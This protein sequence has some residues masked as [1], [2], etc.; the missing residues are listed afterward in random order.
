MKRRL[1]LR[2]RKYTIPNIWRHANDEN[3]VTVAETAYI[4]EAKTRFSLMVSEALKGKKVQQAS[5]LVEG[6]KDL[7]P[8]I[9]IRSKNGNPDADRKMFQRISKK[10]NF[11]VH[12]NGNRIYMLKED[13]D[14]INNR[15]LLGMSKIAEYFGIHRKTLT[16]WLKLFRKMPVNRKRDM[17]FKPDIDLWYAILQFNKAKNKEY[18]KLHHKNAPIVESVNRIFI[19]LVQMDLKHPK[20]LKR[21]LLRPEENILR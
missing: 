9:G 15:Y 1:K 8:A 3:S 16:K 2:M 10:Y 13:I 17:A 7:C 20:E 12:H 18:I 4:M 19:I 5:Q 21:Y 6:W 11:P 14:L